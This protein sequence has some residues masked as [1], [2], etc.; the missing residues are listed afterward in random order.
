[1]SYPWVSERG[2]GQ[3]AWEPG[4]GG[5]FGSQAPALERQLRDLPHQIDDERIERDKPG[6][7]GFFLSELRGILAA[8]DAGD[9]DDP[10]WLE[11]R[12]RCLDRMAKLL[13]VY[14]ADAPQVKA[15][16]GDAR[17]L[18]RQATEALDALEASLA[19][20]RSA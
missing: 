7:R 20:T 15:G 13:R 1:M 5:S 9:P 11:I 17:A 6:H 10:R 16:P 18:V 2:P 8:C 3:V 12:M 4:A 19:E 14:E